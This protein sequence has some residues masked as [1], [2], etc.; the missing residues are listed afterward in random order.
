MKIL[1]YF[2]LLIVVGLPLSVLAQ[3]KPTP[4]PKATEQPKEAKKPETPPVPQEVRNALRDNQWEQAKILNQLT[5][6]KDYYAKQQANLDNLI[7]AA[8]KLINEAPARAGVDPEKYQ[9][10]SD[11]M[12]FEVKKETPKP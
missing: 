8:E 1:K 10:N 11:T 4:A 5:Q 9:L 12:R 7:K 3:D 6:L 2:F